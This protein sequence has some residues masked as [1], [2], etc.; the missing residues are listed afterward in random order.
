MDQQ[1]SIFVPE[2]VPDGYTLKSRVP[3]VPGLYPTVVF[4]YR[5]AAH[6][7]FAEVA[8]AAPS[9]REDVVCRVLCKHLV[10]LRVEGDGQVV[11]LNVAQAARLHRGIFQAIFDTVMG[12]LGPDVAEMEKNSSPG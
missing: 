12:Y 9:D 10:D 6:G 5:P 2:F 7:A 1:G 3:G 11:K 4:T 8:N